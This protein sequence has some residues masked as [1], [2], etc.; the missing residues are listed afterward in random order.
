[1]AGL[2]TLE[3]APARAVGGDLD[4]RFGT[5][6]TVIITITAAHDHATSVALQPDG[7]IVVAGVAGCDVALVR[8]TRA[9]VLDR[10]FGTGGIV[11]THITGVAKQRRRS[12]GVT[13]PTHEYDA[14]KGP[15]VSETIES[16]SDRIDQQQL[17]QELVD[18]ARAEGVLPLPVSCLR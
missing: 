15:V 13:G 2:P 10:R 16:M 3:L 14:G 5:G 6:G 11:P 12:A 4:P 18:S 8:Y 17:A 7:K 9:G 1:M